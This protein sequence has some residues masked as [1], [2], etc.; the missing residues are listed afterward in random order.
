MDQMSTPADIRAS[1][2]RY[3]DAKD[4]P[5]ASDIL[6]AAAVPFIAIPTDGFMEPEVQVG[7]LQVIGLDAIRAYAEQFKQAGVALR[8]NL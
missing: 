2:V 1:H 3:A 6:S 4:A 7:R 8:L 5:E